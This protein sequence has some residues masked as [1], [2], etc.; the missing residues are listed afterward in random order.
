MLVE[1]DGNDT[2]LTF[3]FP[4]S[5]DDVWL[6]LGYTSGIY[7]I[8][9]RLRCEFCSPP[10]TCELNDFSCIVKQSVYVLSSGLGGTS[11]RV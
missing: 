6:T 4:E 9:Q 8:F 7:F 5:L 3:R 10:T 11:K 1:S 2:K